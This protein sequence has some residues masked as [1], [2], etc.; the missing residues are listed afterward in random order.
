PAAVY[1]DWPYP[2]YAPYY[3]PPPAG[4][5]AGG[6]LATGVAFAAGVAVRHAF[7]GNCDWGRG[8]INVVTNRS[9]NIA[10]VNRGRW[11]HNPDHRQ[12]VRYNNADVR[13]KFAKTD[14]QAGR[15]PEGTRARSRTP[16]WR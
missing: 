16:W 1:G 14:I 11:E 4:Y 5:F 2:D 12:G 15:R 8:N 3:F 7:W 13:Q 10:N 6:V 9:A